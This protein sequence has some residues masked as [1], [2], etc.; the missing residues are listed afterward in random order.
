MQPALDATEIRF[1][2]ALLHGASATRRTALS[3]SASSLPPR[4][5]LAP[6]GFDRWRNAA[7]PSS[8]A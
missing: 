8:T 3:R 4:G 5:R 7:R 1:Q 6:A 2:Q